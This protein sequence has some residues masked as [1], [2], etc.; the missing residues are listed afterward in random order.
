[1]HNILCKPQRQVYQWFLK[2]FDDFNGFNGL[3]SC[4]IRR[5]GQCTDVYHTVLDQTNKFEFRLSYL[6]DN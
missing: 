4:T 5:E 1:M 3:V 2:P 6:R